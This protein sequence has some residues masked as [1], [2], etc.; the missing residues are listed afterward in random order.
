MRQSVQRGAILNPFSLKISTA[1]CW[2]RNE[3]AEEIDSTNKDA[4]RL[5]YVGPLHNRQ[6]YQIRAMSGISINSAG[7][8]RAAL[9]YRSEIDGLR[10]TAVI[11]VCLFHADIPPFSGGYV[12]VDVFF[13][14]S[15][16]LMASIIG[17]ELTDGRFSFLFFYERRVRRIFPA[18]FC[19]LFFCAIGASLLVP[20]QL[21]QEF[22]R[23]LVAT[24]FFSSNVIFAL[25]SSN[26]FDAPVGLNPLLHTWSLGVEE[27]FYILFPIFLAIIWRLGWSWRFIATAVVA[28]TSLAISIWGAENAPTASFYLLPPRAWELLIGAMVGLLHMRPRFQEGPA[29]PTWVATAVSCLGLCLMLASFVWFDSETAIPGY[30][31]LAPCVGVALLLHF[32][33]SQK[34]FVTRLLSLR[35]CT[36]VGKISY[37]LYLWHWP[38]IVLVLRYDFVSQSGL[39]IK[40]LVLAAAFALSVVT[41]RLVEQ[42]FRQRSR[43][44]RRTVFASA[45][46]VTAL[47]AI[48]GSW[49]KTSDGWPQR[50]PGLALVAL[51]P[52]LQR[53]QSDTAWADFE[54]HND[55]FAPDLA[56]WARDRC[57]LNAGGDSN[58]LLWGDSFAHNYIYGLF[59]NASAPWHVL[60]YTSPQCPPVIG[61]EAASRPQCAAINR[62]VTSIIKD[63]DIK[64]VILAANWQSYVS[65]RKMTYG[66]IARTINMLHQLGL[67]VVLIGQSPEF[68]F[69]YPDEYFYQKYGATIRKGSY[70]A[71]LGIDPRVNRAMA[72]AT[73]ADEFFDPLAVLCDG[74]ECL[75]KQD[76]DYLFEDYGHYTNYGSQR[77]TTALLDKLR[78]DAKAKP[79]AASVAR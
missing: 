17:R 58:A 76:G 54:D 47:F 79:A 63:Y 34:N 78:G 64:T 11:P 1:Y 2:E 28:V 65:R 24:V 10:A 38:L 20:P 22:G 6:I 27:Q 9:P 51:G 39:G 26:Y 66:D 52:Q 46:C 62:S 35:P 50:Y 59:R 5:K 8:R 75:F 41:W 16:Y 77:M 19:V 48:A 15:G 21:F 68:S 29:V 14:I 40:C 71:E 69:A 44:P 67:R 70:F 3:S 12:G 36:F 45:V 73:T 4:S 31:A 72:S 25:G 61:Y 55:C 7:A 18:L 49:A 53:E 33:R 74:K 43:I 32:A 57:W 56:S 23:S 13:V 60:A 30:A 37:S 42:P